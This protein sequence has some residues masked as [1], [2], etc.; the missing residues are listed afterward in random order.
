MGIVDENRTL[1]EGFW[2]YLY[3]QDFSA[4]G[5]RF[6]PEAEYTDVVPPDDESLGGLIEET[7]TPKVKVHGALVA[8]NA[9]LVVTIST[10]TS[11]GSLD[12][13]PPR[14]VQAGVV[15]KTSVSLVGTA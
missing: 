6:H 11:T 13:A 5:F 2:A 10:N 8:S 4:L 9:S 15:D 3:R 14:N 7:L 1:I 12:P